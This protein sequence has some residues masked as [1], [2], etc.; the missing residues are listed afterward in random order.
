VAFVER[1]SLGKA[2]GSFCEIDLPPIVYQYNHSMG[3][4]D[5]LVTVIAKYRFLLRLRRCV[6][7][8]REAR[9]PAVKTTSSYDLPFSRYSL[10][11]V[12]PFNR[13]N[14]GGSFVS[15]EN[16]RGVGQWATGHRRQPISDE[17]RWTHW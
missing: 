10:K 2:N 16:Y 15:F 6:C 13:P 17:F 5:L 8:G 9:T 11:E 4:V 1:S 3:G 14:L 12:A 7:K